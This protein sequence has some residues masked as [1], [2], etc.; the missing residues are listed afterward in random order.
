MDQSRINLGTD[1]PADEAG[2]GSRRAVAVK[3]PAGWFYGALVIALTAWI[4]HGFVHALLA[5]CVTAIA[6]WPL[7]RKFAACLPRCVAQ[8]ATN[9]IFTL[10]MVV[11]VLAPVTFGFGALV[12]EAHALLLEIAAADKVGIATPPWFERIPLVGTWMAARWQSE[13][14]HPGALLAWAERTDATALLSWVQSLGQFMVRHAFIIV[15]TI[16]VLFFLYREGETL[17]HQFRRLLHQRIGDAADGYIGLA[18]RALRASVNSMLV[19]ALFDG[20]GTWAVYA[21]AG[22]PHAATWA[23]ITGSLALVPFL[24]YV[25]VIALALKLTIAGAATPALLSFALGCAVLFCGDKL[26]R[27]VLARDATQLPFVWI[28]M[29][30]LGGFEVLGLEGLVIG[31]VLL[32]ITKELWKQRASPAIP[33]VTH[34]TSPISKGV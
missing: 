15:F 23:A 7:Y 22:A 11:F 4:L 28:L 9:L 32:T 24:G 14:A 3:L 1:N 26:V 25:A 30:C 29:G 20:F 12:S 6:S 34:A 16:L 21:M 8:S 19:V 10:L 33:E 5:A 2:S 27:P 17:A 13:L 18:T 31:P